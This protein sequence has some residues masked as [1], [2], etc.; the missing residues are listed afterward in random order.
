MVRP[1]GK[2]VNQ[3]V[4]RIIPPILLGAVIYGSYV[5]TKQLCSEYPRTW[6]PRFEI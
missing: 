6:L 3:A 1:P 2:R 5:V 4:S